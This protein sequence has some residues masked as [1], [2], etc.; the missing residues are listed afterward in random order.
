[1]KQ[2]GLPIRGAACLFS[3]A[4]FSFTFMAVLIQQTSHVLARVC[5]GAL[6]GV[7]GNQQLAT[8]SA[9]TWFMSRH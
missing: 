7:T 8:E 2:K 5:C 6:L 9:K 4:L 1:M 3:Q